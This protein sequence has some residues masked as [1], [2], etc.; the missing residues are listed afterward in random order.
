M[1]ILKKIGLMSILGI[2]G[3]GGLYL[4]ERHSIPGAISVVSPAEARVGRPLS[5]V[6]VAGVARRHAQT[7]RP[8]AAG[9]SSWPFTCT[10]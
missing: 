9:A 2:I 10:L 1:R 7:C 4:G 8:V 6:S 3:L 5:P